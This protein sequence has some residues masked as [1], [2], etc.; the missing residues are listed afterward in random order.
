MAL[1][2]WFL[3][4]HAEQQ[5]TPHDFT[6]VLQR[7]LFFFTL[8]WVV[9]SS[10]DRPAFVFFSCRLIVVFFPGANT[11]IFLFFP[12]LF[13]SPF[14]QV[15]FVPFFFPPP[16][17]LCLTF[18][19]CSPSYV[20]PPPLYTSLSP[21][22][23]AFFSFASPAFFFFFYGG[24]QPPRFPIFPFYSGDLVCCFFSFHRRGSKLHLFFYIFSPSIRLNFPDSP[25]L[26]A[27]GPSLLFFPSP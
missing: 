14:V 4:P 24:F 18:L 26:L 11:R 25:V 22:G 19:C 15:P 17:L 6:I 8:F 9:N 27:P 2:N 10:C 23:L 5:Q 3:T 12:R 1:F 21:D 20:S 16:T 7:S 13:S